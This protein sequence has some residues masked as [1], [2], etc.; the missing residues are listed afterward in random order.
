MWVVDDVIAETS[1]SHA[2]HV[3]LLL[4]SQEA[5]KEREQE[6][7]K[8]MEWEKQIKGKLKGP[9]TK[10]TTTKNKLTHSL[11]A[12]SCKLIFYSV[13]KFNFPFHLKSFEAI[14]S[15]FNAMKGFR[16]WARNTG[17]FYRALASFKLSYTSFIIIFC[18]LYTLDFLI[19]VIKFEHRNIRIIECMKDNE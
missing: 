2:H 14:L 16:V 19:N 11:H 13:F 3:L 8:Q 5:E 6:M 7:Q 17:W 10:Q 12:R 15:G 1:W 4:F 18:I 9:W